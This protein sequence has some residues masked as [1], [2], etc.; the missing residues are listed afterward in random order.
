MFVHR[1]RPERVIVLPPKQNAF[2][3]TSWIVFS[4]KASEAADRRE[5]GDY[6]GWGTRDISK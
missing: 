4:R 1:L 6:F 2:W 5:V 3:V